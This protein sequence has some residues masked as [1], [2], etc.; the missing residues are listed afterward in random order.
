[1]MHLHRIVAHVE[2]HIG[3][4]KEV[5]G[6]VLLDDVAFI[7]RADDEII[8]SVAAVYLEDMPQ[9]RAPADLDHG[10]WL[11]G[12]FFAQTGAKAPCKDD[13]F[14]SGKFRDAPSRNP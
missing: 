12:G 13:G 5:I 10:F 9:D 6:K 7:A 1:M 14:H 11:E 3:H 2:R 4:V 8:D